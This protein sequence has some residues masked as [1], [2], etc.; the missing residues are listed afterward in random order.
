MLPRA[1]NLAWSRASLIAGC[2]GFGSWGGCGRRRV[3]HD[4]IG[5]KVDGCVQHVGVMLEVVARV[6]EAHLH[7]RVL[8][9]VDEV[10]LL[11]LEVER[12]GMPSGGHSCGDPEEHRVGLTRLAVAV[13]PVRA[14]TQE[15]VLV[16]AQ[17]VLP[18]PGARRT[19]QHQLGRLDLRRVRV[20]LHCEPHHLRHMVQ[21]EHRRLRT[22]F[23][24]VCER[25]VPALLVGVRVGVDEHGLVLRRLVGGVVRVRQG[26]QV[27]GQ[28]G[29]GGACEAGLGLRVVAERRT[30]PRQPAGCHLSIV[31]RRQQQQRKETREETSLHGAV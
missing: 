21:C 11:E 16:A 14:T 23:H 12:V 27:R 18:R 30:S 3:E 25:H 29:G 5:V 8:E 13:A 28:R 9:D 19:V 10:R 4:L 31:G 1:L 20:V 24:L 2:S 6:H 15:G 22:V 17:G 26:L 7:I